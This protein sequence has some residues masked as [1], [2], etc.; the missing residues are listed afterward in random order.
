MP[1]LAAEE[2]EVPRFHVQGFGTLTVEGL[3]FLDRWVAC[4]RSGCRG[5]IGWGHTGLRPGLSGR[6]GTTCGK[7]GI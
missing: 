3:D 1:G 5:R 4:L 7:R 6:S 2:V